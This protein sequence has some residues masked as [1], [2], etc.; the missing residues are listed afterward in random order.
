MAS[1]LQFRS[2]TPFGVGFSPNVAGWYANRADVVSSNFYPAGRDIEGWFNPAAFAVPAQFA[3]G[4]SARNM[5]FGP[6]QKIIDISFL[7]ATSITEKFRT[8]FRAEFFNFPNHPS[9]GNPAANI[10][11]P[12]SVGKIRGTSVEARVVQF[13]LKLLF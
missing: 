6:G 13:G 4:S 9:F 2:G 10:S 8:E 3:F 7:K 5:L 1:I 12:A 11:V